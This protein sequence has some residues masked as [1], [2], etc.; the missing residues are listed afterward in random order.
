MTGLIHAYVTST[1]RNNTSIIGIYIPICKVLQVHKSESSEM[2][3][4]DLFTPLIEDISRSNHV[5]VHID[6]VHR[7]NSI[8]HNTT[9]ATIKNQ[10]GSHEPHQLAFKVLIKECNKLIKRLFRINLKKASQPLEA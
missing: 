6:A 4:L 10:R 2:G 8:P 5:V 1:L 7:Y 3:A 9:I